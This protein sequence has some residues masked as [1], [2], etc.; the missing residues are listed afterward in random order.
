MDKNLTKEY[1]EDIY[2]YPNFNKERFEFTKSDIISAIGYGQTHPDMTNFE[3]N[4][5][6]DEILELIKSN[7]KK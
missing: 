7:R 6:F 3:I 5:N 1:F 2:G 4:K